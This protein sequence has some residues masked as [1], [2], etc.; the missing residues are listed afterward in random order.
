MEIEAVQF[1]FHKILWICYFQ[2][3]ILKYVHLL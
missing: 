3:K 1:T 2:T